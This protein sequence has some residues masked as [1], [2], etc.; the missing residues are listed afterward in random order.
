MGTDASPSPNSHT[1]CAKCGAPARLRCSG[2]TEAPEYKSDE[3]IQPVYYCNGKCQGEH[4]PE[5]KAPCGVMQKRKK[6]L[7][8]ASILKATILA[9]RE[10]AYDLD[11]ERIEFRRDEGVLLLHHRSQIALDYPLYIPFPQLVATEDIHREAALAWNQCTLSVGLFRPLA[12]YLLEGVSCE[13]N[14]TAVSIG[15]PELSI[16]VMCGSVEIKDGHVPSHTILVA[17]LPTNQQH[18]SNEE[19]VIDP[20]GC[21]YGLRDA[22]VPLEKYTRDNQCR[23]EEW[24]EAWTSTETSDIDFAL[25]SPSTTPAEKLDLETERATRLHFA[26]FIRAHIGKNGADFANGL[27]SS[28]EAVFKAKL[29]VFLMDVK[30]HMTEFVA[31]KQ[32]R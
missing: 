20:T 29:D 21:Q 11:I 23:E 30:M 1:K 18:N 10:C 5:H 4:W 2:C 16:K 22:L 17:E 13:T 15:K 25:A 28:S 32:L 8:I 14:I 27:L 3:A 24:L 19:W 26:S 7:R 6:L 9:Y 31:K 12:R